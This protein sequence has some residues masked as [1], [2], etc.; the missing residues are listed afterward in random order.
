K[1]DE[2]W[3]NEQTKCKELATGLA[4]VT[5]KSKSNQGT[6]SMGCQ[7]SSD[8]VLETDL[9]VCMSSESRQCENKNNEQLVTEDNSGSTN[10]HF[11]EGLKLKNGKPYCDICRTSLT[12]EKA[13]ED[14]L[15]GKPHQKK[16][17][18]VM[19]AIPVS[20]EWSKPNI[21]TAAISQAASVNVKS[22]PPCFQPNPVSDKIEVSSQPT[23][24]HKV[25]SEKRRPGHCR[26]EGNTKKRLTEGQSVT[27]NTS[28]WGG[29]K[30][31]NGKQYC[32][33]CEAVLTSQAVADAH[34][35]GKQHEK[36]LNKAFPTGQSAFE[37]RSAPV[38][39]LPASSGISGM[40][41]SLGLSSGCE[42]AVSTTPMLFGNIKT[43][44]YND[45]KILNSVI[46]EAS[47]TSSVITPDRSHATTASLK[48]T[49]VRDEDYIV[50]NN[51]M[52]ECK[53]CRT[54]VTSGVN[55]AQHLQGG[56]HKKKL[57]ALRVRDVCLED[58]PEL[59]PHGEI[60]ILAED[61]T[62][63]CF[64]C[65]APINSRESAKQHMEGRKHINQCKRYGL[66]ADEWD[67]VSSVC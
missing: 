12:S 30:M 46:S 34:C 40:P 49:S 28:C 32:D 45:K 33:L 16:L 42:T 26:G 24:D 11:W 60:I 65:S 57:E 19:E 41:T 67:F 48:Q 39:E 20:Q 31:K 25:I 44:S 4:N 53:L 58:A 43:T 54:P 55:A 27:A 17:K 10:Q 47:T 6:I 61:G 2:K 1:L 66:P 59:G 5:L 38:S 29:L 63:K 51:G 23:F 14:H 36:K 21:T 9:A 7:L 18:E 52:L 37:T 13:A 15:K 3:S 35:K 8:R 62:G 50:D 64:V 22:T 56:K